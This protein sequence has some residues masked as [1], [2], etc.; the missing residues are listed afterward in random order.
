MNF[1]YDIACISTLWNLADL[2]FVVLFN[3]IYVQNLSLLNFMMC[4]VQAIIFMKIQRL[5]ATRVDVFN[6]YKN[7]SMIF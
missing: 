2:K 4:F 6:V 5:A 7:T 3:K 1:H